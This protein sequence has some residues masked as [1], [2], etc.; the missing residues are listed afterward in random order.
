MSSRAIRRVSLAKLSVAGFVLVALLTTAF[1][2]RMGRGEAM[3]AT[4]TQEPTR[5]A[6]D[7]GIEHRV[8][9]LLGKMRLNEKL[10]QVQLLS[11]G[12]ITDAD[13]RKGCLLYT[14]PS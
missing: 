13:A 9:A 4:P 12:Q 8:E 3:S 11:D 14:S 10:Q 2:L 5:Q 7:R 1:M 6:A